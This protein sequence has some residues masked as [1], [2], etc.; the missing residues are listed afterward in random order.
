MK[1]KAPAS[2]PYRPAAEP[3]RSATI[4]TT[5]T[6]LRSIARFITGFALVAL[7]LPISPSWAQPTQSSVT[8]ALPVVSRSE[9]PSGT[10]SLAVEWIK[11]VAP[12]QGVMLAA[13]ASP[14]GAGPFPTV[15]LLH[16]T[17]GFAREYVQLAEALAHEGLLAVA[18]CWF[19][20]GSG[21]GA[22]FVTPIDCPEAPPQR[23]ASDAAT[24][25]VVDTLVAAAR[26]LPDARPDRIGLF[27]HSRGGGAALNYVLATRNVRAAALNSAGYPGALTEF[28]SQVSAPLL[29]LHGTADSPAEGGSAFTNIQMA[30]DF[31]E[32][33]R[34]IGKPV[35]SQYYEGSGHNSLFTSP[36]QFDD[37]AK[38]MAVFFLRNLEN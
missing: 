8:I 35:E 6:P 31:E 26:T 19:S 4:G 20:G 10:E 12:G 38:H 29:I 7:A 15:V 27:G 17:H 13:V 23:E 11:V 5:V 18:A 3:G 37:E 9:P 24:L 30:R 2:N 32:A 25:Q 1:S 21:A 16:G 14:S 34:R 28:V 22:R 36:G 33:L